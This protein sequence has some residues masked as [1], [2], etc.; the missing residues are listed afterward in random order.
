L[1]A[2]NGTVVLGRS[3][4]ASTPSAPVFATV[5]GVP[6]SS[7]R[8]SKSYTRWTYTAVERPGFPADAVPATWPADAAEVAVADLDLDGVEDFVFPEARAL[9]SW[10][11]AT[12]LGLL[13]RLLGVVAFDP[14]AQYRRPVPRAWCSVTS[15]AGDAPELMVPSAAR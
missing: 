9:D 6:R 15:P 10:T 7:S 5:A 1:I 12:R 4:F 2:P 14:R 13:S 11:C 3:S 8:C